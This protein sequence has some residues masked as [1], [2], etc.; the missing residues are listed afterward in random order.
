[1]S[2]LGSIGSAIC[3]VGSAI[4]SGIST[5][6]SA[7]ISVG[8]A[9]FNFAAEYAPK[10]AGAVSHF[11]S[12]IN[13]I[14]SAVS[15]ALN[16]F[17]HGENME[18][19]GDRALQAAEQGIKPEN[20]RKFDEYAQAI[21]DFRLD[22][23]KTEKTDSATKIM[24][25]LAVSSLGLEDKLGLPAGMGGAVWLLAASKPEYFTAARLEA[26]LR[27]PSPARTLEYF[28]G[29]LGPAADLKTRDAIIDIERTLQP[30]QTVEAI[31]KELVE[32]RQA[33]A[34]MQAAPS[35]NER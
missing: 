35:G 25:G 11:G 5:V 3:S 31:Y 28:E 7:A 27:A 29:K 34:N 20:Y 21:R 14:A 13:S 30:A 33:V 22:P 4:S 12:V 32:A 17:R 18:N 8:R 26:L 24:A 2:I 16:I 6:C 19:M 15:L 1:M 23:A 9:A 10:I